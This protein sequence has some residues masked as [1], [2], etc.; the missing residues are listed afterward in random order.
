MDL[1]GGSRIRTFDLGRDDGGDA[2]ADWEKDDLGELHFEVGVWICSRD[3][4]VKSGFE[5]L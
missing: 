5:F 1:R 2:N 3:C 4:T